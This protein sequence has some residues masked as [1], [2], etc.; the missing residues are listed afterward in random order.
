MR[1]GLPTR[2]TWTSTVLVLSAVLFVFG[3]EEPDI[4]NP[5]A[6]SLTPHEAYATSL[7][8]AGLTGTALGRSWLEAGTTILDTASPIPL[9]FREIRYLD[10]AQPAAV[11]YRFDLAGRR[12]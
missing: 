7:E 9:P 5:F 4:I 11:G 3:C 8:E 2:W 12:E 1:N 6:R 10:P